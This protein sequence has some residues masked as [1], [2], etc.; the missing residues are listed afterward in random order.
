MYLSQIPLEQQGLT[1]LR[2]MLNRSEFIA[3]DTETNG[4]DV[5]DGRGICYGVSVSDGH[6]SMYLPF[7][8]RQLPEENLDFHLYRPLLQE[9]LD[10]KKLIYFNAKFDIVSL[11]T[12]GLDT[13]HKEFFDCMI[14][15]HLVD[16]NRPFAGKNL[17]ACAKMYCGN[18][19]KKVS[20]EY[21]WCLKTYGYENMTASITSDY[22]ATDALITYQLYMKLLPYLRAEKLKEMW[23]HKREFIELLID[24]ESEGV[25]VDQDL[26]NE[27]AE[28]G[29][30]EMERIFFTLNT[31]NPASTRDLEYLL[32]DQ[33]HL[34]VV[35]RT[36][37]GKP[38]FNKR[39]MELYDLMLERSNN[40]LAKQVFAYR[41]W[42]KSV[43]SN[44]RPYVRLLS[45][46]ARLRGN[47]FMHSTVTGRLSCKEPNLQ[48]I[49]REGAK[50]WNGKMKKCFIP[51][52]GYVL[53][54][55]DYKQLEFRLSASFAK[56]PLLLA[57]FHDP[58]RDVFDEMSALLEMER[59]E[60]KTLEYTLSYGGGIPRIMAAFGVSESRA[61]EI[62][63]NHDRTYPNL[64]K[65]STYASNY[66][67]AN[68]KI[69]IWSGRYRHFLSPKT[70][71]YKAYNS[72][73]QGGAA[74]IM[75]RTMLR[76]ANQGYNTDDCRMLLQVHDSIIWE[77][78]EDLAPEIKP[79][80]Q[81]V[82]EDVTPSFGV[83]F[84]VDLHVWGEAA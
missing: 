63:D 82:M 37:K 22:A 81:A 35:G 33:L 2:E 32:I 45:P 69:P 4:K 72:L 83:P 64:R 46:D 76:A 15:A 21:A 75:E 20:E 12:L 78:R 11:G 61:K 68:K 49:P 9:L 5:R 77:V 36:P 53:L 30:R 47:Y 84:N 44:Y 42:Q 43:S 27:M 8:H 79:R 31:R 48:Q 7:R 65:A 38:S 17:D 28:R 1:L 80:L 16:E 41:G 6:T 54:E 10:T 73:C 24:M 18:G 13:R 58:T 23:E 14:L 51:K 74:D 50:P 67:V 71:A 60:A 55:G 59:Y 62:R 40:P 39:A 25:L 66:V 26:C 34:P 52:P 57:A 3:I 70:E 56:E 29:D 19:G